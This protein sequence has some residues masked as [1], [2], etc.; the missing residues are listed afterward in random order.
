MKVG[1]SFWGELIR[2]DTAGGTG[3][4]QFS[5]VG[6]RHLL[7][8]EFHKQGH[9]V[10]LLQERRELV[11]YPGVE[12]SAVEIPEVDVFYA[13]WRWPMANNS[14]PNPANSDWTR[15]AQLMNEYHHRGT[16]IIVFDTDMKIRPEDEFR[17]NR[18]IVGEPTISHSEI[19]R[20]RIRLNWVTDFV[21]YYD[22]PTNPIAYCYLGN[23]YERTDQ[24]TKYYGTPAPYLRDVGIQTVVHGNWL[25]RSSERESPEQILKNFKCVDFG[26]RLSYKDGMRMMASSICTSNLAKSEYYKHGFVTSRI[27]ESI[28]TGIPCLTPTEH[29]HLAPVGLGDWLIDSPEDVIGKV[30]YLRGMSQDARRDLVGRQL[31]ELKKLGDFSPARKVDTIIGVASERITQGSIDAGKIE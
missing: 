1:Y 26:S 21:P 5:A 16:P 9:T 18:M 4:T 13:E 23:N 15:Q 14:G 12:Y 27:Y 6:E 29:K 3:T 19:L 20:K 8:E 22:T 10:V 30:T 31:Q 7:V 17:W 25:E 11:P 2:P 24:F 28:L